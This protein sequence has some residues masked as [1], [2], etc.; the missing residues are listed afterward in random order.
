MKK[1]CFLFIFVTELIIAQVA[2]YKHQIALDLHPFIKN[3][4]SIDFHYNNAI[5]DR[6]NIG[7]T[8]SINFI[9]NDP[10]TS[11]YVQ[12]TDT[13]IT[14]YNQNCETVWILFIPIDNCYG[15]IDSSIKSDYDS[16]HQGFTDKI[17]LTPVINYN[18][19]KGDRYRLYSLLGVGIH[20]GNSWKVNTK[21]KYITMMDTLYQNVSIE[22]IPIIAGTLNEQTIVKKVEIHNWEEITIVDKNKVA[23]SLLLGIGANFRLYKSIAFDFNLSS[24][25]RYQNNKV[26]VAMIPVAK[27]GWMF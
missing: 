15:D 4:K 21:N 9:N 8:L 5:N 12:K 13:T 11:I 18:I 25:M 27:I 10:K 1:I 20:F 6:I 2:G 14:T 24:Q 17:S 19:Q 3:S 7:G 22:G 16:Y 26:S 23:T